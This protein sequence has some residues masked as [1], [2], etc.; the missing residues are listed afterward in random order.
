M[1]FGIKAGAVL[2]GATIALA[3]Q[4][5][6]AGSYTVK[7][8]PGV[9]VGDVVTKTSAAGASF[10][11]PMGFGASWGEAGIG[12]YS[13]TFEG[14]SDDVDGAA[15]L[16]LGLG[17]AKKAVG[18]EV[19]MSFSSLWGSANSGG[20]FG[21]NGSFSAKLH[22]R[23][24]GSAAIAVGVTGLG[25]FGDSNDVR[26]SSLYVVGTKVFKLSKYALVANVGA[27]NK[28]F[29]QGDDGLSPL[30]SL[31]F[32]FNPQ[33]SLIADYNG[34]VLNAG[35]SVAP[36]KQYPLTVTLGAINT[37]QRFGGDAEF[38]AMASYG[39]RF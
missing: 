39:F 23:L 35:V 9:K 11:S 17:D 14:A 24:P 18:L 33:V 32:Y 29:N 31:A 6:D 4:A 19:G 12:L 5:Q 7:L 15:G 22:T 10:G 36:F 16:V 8:P 3:A 25:R 20:S 38:G 13:Q 26:E 27:G 1:K 37:T 28:F 2:L 21:D 34:N 30:G